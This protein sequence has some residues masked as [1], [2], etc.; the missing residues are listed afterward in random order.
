[1]D[2]SSW[3]AVYRSLTLWNIFNTARDA[4]QCCSVQ[5]TVKPGRQPTKHWSSTTASRPSQPFRRIWGRPITC[6]SD[7]F[8]QNSTKRPTLTKASTTSAWDV[9]TLL[10]QTASQRRCFTDSWAWT[11]TPNLWVHRFQVVF[12]RSSSI[13]LIVPCS[14][15]K[16]AFSSFQ[17]P[18]GPSSVLIAQCKKNGHCRKCH[19]PLDPHLMHELVDQ[20]ST[21]PK[22]RREIRKFNQ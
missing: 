20:T 3:Y 17:L 11:L 7:T 15:L 5:S 14:A 4:E 10:L 1:M 18:F 22:R 9:W 12:S 13:I 2:A 21:S 16:I 8:I 19:R 6:G